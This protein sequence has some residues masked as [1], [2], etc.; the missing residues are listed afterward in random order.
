M[1][2]QLRYYHKILPFQHLGMVV[3]EGEEI[4]AGVSALQTAAA[5]LGVQVSEISLDRKNY[6]PEEYQRG[7]ARFFSQFDR[8]KDRCLLAGYFRN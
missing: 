2:R 6:E 3:P 7:A 1:Q 4:I 8:S 5:S